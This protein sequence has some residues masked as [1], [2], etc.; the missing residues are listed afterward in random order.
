MLSIFILF[1]INLNKSYK[2]SNLIN[3]LGKQRM[4]TQMMAKDVGRIYVLNSIIDGTL[5]NS[6]QE[7]L[8]NRRTEVLEELKNSKDEYEKQYTTIKQGYIIVEGKSVSFKGAKKKLDTIFK[9]HDFIWENFKKA[10]DTVLIENS[11]SQNTLQAIEYINENN[12]KLLNYSN[13]I[14][15]IVL[16]YNNNKSLLIYYSIIVL[17]IL[18]LIFLALF[19]RNAYRDLFIPISQ[20]YKGMSQI[21][22][23]I[24]NS[25]L[26]KEAKS[27]IAPVFSIVSSTLALAKLTE[28]RDP[29]TGEHLY[30]MK[31][32]SRMIAEFL[33]KEEK[34][35]NV[36]VNYMREYFMKEALKEAKRALMLKEVPVG[37]VIV[38]DNKIISRA[39][40]LK[41]TLKEPTAHAEIMA[42]KKACELLNNWRLSGCE[43]YVT[44]EPCPM[45][46]SAIAQARI[47]KLYIGTFD[48]TAGACGSVIDVLG[49]PYLNYKVKVNWLH[50][51]ECS[52]ILSC[53]FKDR[54]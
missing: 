24:E 51:E 41:E 19:I 25:L 22:I 54:R 52:K 36:V 37:A 2:D 7:N 32:Y 10:I 20:L 18:I 46:A 1:L 50:N 42:I 3:I 38:K 17:V 9:E 14:T 27:N 43:L 45:C 16:D 49:N 35:K 44:L 12:E 47:S 34:Y 8:Q 39:Y 11:N 33:S 23:T 30:R 6:G 15:H 53:F 48:P 31:V 13:E 4:L 28:E 40:N 29:E 21:G 5:H 26:P